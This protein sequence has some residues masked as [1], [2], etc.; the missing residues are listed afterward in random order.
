MARLGTPIPDNVEVAVSLLMPE[1]GVPQR[2]S[3]PEL[4]APRQPG[5]AAVAAAETPQQQTVNLESRILYLRSYLLMRA[6]IGFIG[7]TLPI[8]LVVGDHL[9][10]SGGPYIRQALSDYYYSGVRDFFVGA[11]FAA[12]I[13]LITYKVFEKNLNNLL[14]IVAGLAAFAVAIFPTDRPDAPRPV[15]T[16]VQTHLGEEVVSRVHFISAAV[17]IISLGI[18]CFFFGLQEGRRTQQRAGRRAMLP[19]NFWRWFHWVCAA[20]ILT[21]VV[22]MVI[23]PTRDAFMGHIR[24]VGETVAIL[25]FGLSW[26]FK[27]LELDILLGGPRRAGRRWE[28]QA[29]AQTP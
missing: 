15:L 26:L 2:P 17:F 28:R 9:L 4:A 16:P 29:A 13:F 19:P 5:A 1:S 11:M 20:A 23:T 12:G 10:N 24:F 7:V 22:F 6:V 14:T 3:L 8:A 21:S 27:G 18:L 25:A